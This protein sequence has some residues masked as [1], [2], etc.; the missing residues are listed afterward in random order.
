MPIAVSPVPNTPLS[1]FPQHHNV[2]V[3]LMPQV[4]SSAAATEAHTE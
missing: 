4:H 3:V 1:L 2:P